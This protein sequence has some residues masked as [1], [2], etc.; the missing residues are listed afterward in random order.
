MNNSF[1]E[2]RD[3]AIALDGKRLLEIDCRVGP[4]EVL[5]VMGP[6]GSG[7]SS[8]LSYIAGFLAPAFQASGNV[9][10]NGNE[11]TALPAER[12]RIG[13]LF[14]D[15]LLFPHLSIAGNLRFAVPKQSNDKNRL[16]QQGL[17]DI[18]LSGFDDRDPGTL[19]GGQR[20]RVALL[21]LLLSTPNAVLLDEP[22]SKLD[23]QLRQEIRTLVFDRLRASGLPTILV[24]HDQADADAASGRIHTLS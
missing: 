18:G 13:L 2:L 9:V 21:R 20:S 3:V 1:L 4:G 7:K 14:Q 22:F 11:I 15:P 10:V 24:T 16:I 6:S 12:R 8:L 23:T 19:S 17:A 5:T